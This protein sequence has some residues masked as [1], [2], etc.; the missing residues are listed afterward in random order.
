MT[1]DHEVEVEECIEHEVVILDYDT[2]EALCAM[3][4]VGLAAI[5]GILGVA[6]SHL[7]KWLMGVL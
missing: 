7:A 4:M 6:V 5:G 3:A 1:D 2:H